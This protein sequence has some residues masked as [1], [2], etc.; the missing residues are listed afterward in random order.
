MKTKKRTSHAEQSSANPHVPPYL[1]AAYYPEDWPAGDVDAEIALMR[2]A[3]MNVMRI[4]EFAWSRMEPQEGTYDFGWLHNVVGKL[5]EAGI[6]TIMG[7]PTATPP[8]WLTERYPEVLFV[9]EQGRRHTHGGRCH[10]CPNSPVYRDHCARIV[11]RLAEE[12]GRDRNVLGWQIDNELFPHSAR[13]C[14]CAFCLRKF[15]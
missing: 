13:S 2:E 5:G 15:F 7:T 1:G 9:S 6:R 3:G 4:G 8:A 14:C 12:F 11:A 10:F